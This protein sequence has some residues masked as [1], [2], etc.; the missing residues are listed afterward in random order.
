MR[1]L[2]AGIGA[3]EEAASGTTTGTLAF[4]LAHAGQ[5]TPGRPV[6]ELQMGVEMGRPSRL[7]VELDF[8]A[9]RAVLARLR[10]YSVRMLTGAIEAGY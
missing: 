9:D 7:D 3:T 1:D 8:D 6:L 5:L 10:G 4:A 2:C